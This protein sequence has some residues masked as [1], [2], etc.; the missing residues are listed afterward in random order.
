MQMLWNNEF[1]KNS[2]NT[3]KNTNIKQRNN[4]SLS[5][6]NWL[7]IKSNGQDIKSRDLKKKIEYIF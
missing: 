2:M 4:Y 7:K 3:N 6:P 1:W 5:N